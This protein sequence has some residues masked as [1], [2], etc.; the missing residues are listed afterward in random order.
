[1]TCS[2]S[3]FVSMVTP[4]P[5]S[6]NEKATLRK[7][8]C[9]ANQMESKLNRNL[10]FSQLYLPYSWLATFAHENFNESMALL[11]STQVH[12]IMGG[13]RKACGQQSVKFLFAAKFSHYSIRKVSVNVTMPTDH[14]QK[15]LR[16]QTLARTLMYI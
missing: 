6:E 8:I 9:S 4:V 1:M 16:F 12:C 13:D 2:S 11:H 10:L 3:F 14:T 15:P 5:N 7:T